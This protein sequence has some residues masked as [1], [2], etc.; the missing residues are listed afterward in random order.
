M[1]ASLSEP[2]ES[3]PQIVSIRV[4][5]V[6][7]RGEDGV[8]IKTERAGDAK[9]TR[10]CFQISSCISNAN[11]LNQRMLQWDWRHNR[12]SLG[13]HRGIGPHMEDDM[14]QEFPKKKGMALDQCHSAIATEDFQ[15][16]PAGIE[17]TR[18]FTIYLLG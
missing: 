3:G 8:L 2:V 6:R 16:H 11:H 13:C 15:V 12:D 1:E 10:S 4:A 9:G 5:T 18:L 14:P 7:Y 17:P